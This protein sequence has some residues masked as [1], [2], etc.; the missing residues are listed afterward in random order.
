MKHNTHIYVADKAISLTALAV[1]NT[2]D[3][4]G[5]YFTGSAKTKERLAAK[6]RERLL[7]YYKHLITEATWA[8]DD[9]LRDNHPFHVFKLFMDDEFPGHGMNNLDTFHDSAG[10][11]YYK[12][13][14][15][16]P[17]RIDHMAEEIVTM[18]KLRAYNDQYELRQILYRYLLISHYVVDAHVPNHCDLRDDPP[19][20]D[21][22]KP[23]PAGLYMKDSAHGDLETLWDKAVTPVAL[24]EEIVLPGWDA[25]DENPTA[26]SPDITFDKNSVK[27]G[28]D[29]K[30]QV[31]PQNKLMQFMIDV[32]IRSKNR[33]RQLFPVANPTVRDDT[34]LHQMTKE[35][36]AESIGDLLSVWRYI[37]TRTRGKS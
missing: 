14:G 6:E 21:D 37:W 4:S 7:R 33:A 18:E 10:A 16:L 24:K 5:N 34:V 13:S 15:G 1:D 9:V 27:K 19:S 20:A 30:V 12:F 26:Y 29:I 3:E 35:V 25:P 23:K 28:A 17:Y 32:C 36:F 11:T 22:T 2:V 31:I 8:P